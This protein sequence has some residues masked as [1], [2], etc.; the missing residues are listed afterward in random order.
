[1]SYRALLIDIDGTAVDAEAR[2]RSVVE[3]LALKGGIVINPADWDT[4]AGKSHEDLWDILS[5]EDPNYNIGDPQFRDQ[6]P[7]AKEFS[8]ACEDASTARLDEICANPNVKLAVESHLL[9]GIVVGAVSNSNHHI[10]RLNLDHT[11]Y[12]AD[13]FKTI[14]GKDDVLQADLSPK[15]APDPYYLALRNIN[16]YLHPNT[17]PIKPGEC[18][19]LEDSLTGVQSGLEFWADVIHLTDNSP[20][21]SRQDEINLTGAF[22]TRYFPT[23][24]DFLIETISNLPPNKGL[25]PA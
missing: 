19:V 15:P 23:G 6:F 2:N 9:A 17:D 18:L 12:Q 5:G 24:Q 22:N 13:A 7:I 16:L 8:K 1:M 25:V 21:L 11:G 10:V 14:I 4:L 3:N 20:H